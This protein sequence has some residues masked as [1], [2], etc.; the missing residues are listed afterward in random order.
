MTDISRD[1]VV[2]LLRRAGAV[3]MRMPMSGYST[4]LT[5]SKW[6]AATPDKQ[7][8]GYNPINLRNLPPSPHDIDMMDFVTTWLLY[9]SDDKRVIRKVVALRMLWNADTNRAIHSWRQIGSM[10]RCSHV[11]CRYWH[12]TGVNTIHKQ[13]TKSLPMMKKIGLYRI[14]GS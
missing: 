6:I 7:A 12:E 9:I 13:L 2:I 10:L 3:M 8:Y 5:V 4:G 11:A 14:N 1:E